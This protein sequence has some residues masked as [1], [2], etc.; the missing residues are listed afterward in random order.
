[1][2][3][4]FI[5]NHQEKIDKSGVEIFARSVGAQLLSAMN[6]PDS[7]WANGD[8]SSV[9]PPHNPDTGNYYSGVNFLQLTLAGN[10]G[11]PRWLTSKGMEKN[12]LY[13]S[14][15][16]S[17]ESI[18]HVGTTNFLPVINKETGEHERDLDGALKYEAF[19]RDNPVFTAFKLTN[20]SN[21]DGIESYKTPIRDQGFINARLYE[22]L[23][24][25]GATFKHGDF[26]PRYDEVEDVIYL[27]SRES[28]ESA[29]EY[30]SVAVEQ[31]GR[32][33][34]HKERL[35][36]E[37][38]FDEKTSSEYY[39][40][41]LVSQISNF[42]TAVKVGSKFSPEQFKD[43]TN[44]W[45]RLLDEDP[46]ALL[47]ACSDAQEINNYILSG[48][49]IKRET[50]EYM[51]S[52]EGLEKDIDGR[53]LT[54]SE[55]AFDKHFPKSKDPTVM[56]IEKFEESKAIDG[57]FAGE[58][59]IVDAVKAGGV[60]LTVDVLRVVAKENGLN[61]IT[62]YNDLK[63]DF[64]IGVEHD[65][66]GNIGLKFGV[67]RDN[68]IIAYSYDPQKESY[69]EL[70]SSDPLVIAQEIKNATDVYKQDQIKTH[71]AIKGLESY[72]LD[73]KQDQRSLWAE[74]VKNDIDNNPVKTMLKATEVVRGNDME[75][76]IVNLEN[77]IN[78]RI[79]NEMGYTGLD[80][81]VSKSS[82]KC[83]IFLDNE[84][85]GKP[86]NSKFS[87]INKNLSE[88]INSLK[89]RE[90][91][92]VNEAE[93]KQNNSLVSGGYGASLEKFG[94]MK[95]TLSGIEMSYRGN[96]VSFRDINQGEAFGLSITS[97]G[98]DVGAVAYADDERDGEMVVVMV[99]PYATN[100]SQLD[101]LRGRIADAPKLIK[102]T[103]KNRDQLRARIIKDVERVS[104]LFA[105]PEKAKNLMVSSFED[106][107]MSDNLAFAVL[108]A[109][110][111]IKGKGLSPRFSV[112]E[113][114]LT[115]GKTQAFITVGIE[116]IPRNQM[117]IRLHPVG[118][119]ELILNGRRSN[120]DVRPLR[121]TGIANESR[122]VMVGV[123]AVR[124]MEM[125]AKERPATEKTWIYIN[126]QDKSG[127]EEAKSYG[128]RWDK[129]V[130]CW[131]VD[132]GNDLNKFEKWLDPTFDP[133]AS[134][135]EQFAQALR[136]EGFII[137]ASDIVI[138]NN[139][140]KLTSCKVVGDKGSQKSGRYTM[141]SADFN[142][143]G[144]A[145]GVYTNH[146]LGGGEKMK[147]WSEVGTGIKLTSEQKAQ[148]AK[149]T[150]IRMKEAEEQ[151]AIKYERGG[152]IARALWDEAKGVVGTMSH[153]YV[154]NKNIL[155]HKPLR[156]APLV[157]SSEAHALGIRIAENPKERALILEDARA[158]KED[159][160]VFIAGEL[161]IPA[162]N[163]NGEIRS[164]QKIGS[165][166]TFMSGG[167]KTNNFYTTDGK[168]PSGKAE[169]IIAEGYATADSV[170]RLSRG[171]QVVVAFDVGNMVNVAKL[172]RETYP[173]ARITIA[174]D[175][176][177]H[178]GA[179]KNIGLNKANEVA[180]EIGAIV[181]TPPFNRGAL[182]TDWNDL[183]VEY[184]VSRASEIYQS[185]R[186]EAIA[187]AESRLDV[188]KGSEVADIEIDSDD[189]DR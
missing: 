21:I 146:R 29:E 159:V 91:E 3:N 114:V 63:S 14:E 46:L 37:S 138:T 180:K 184:G 130:K 108:G 121:I 112:D 30:L 58:R 140:N 77:V 32:W 39:K 85:V 84:R 118:K 34:C 50:N 132:R 172:M 44:T 139:R 167:E 158:N 117:H 143:S 43:Y 93:I 150:A 153:R 87:S 141:Y 135:V 189:M 92:A 166:K 25:S 173:D 96:D 57:F 71:G 162:M 70:M 68:G 178:K 126:V 15:G 10:G 59:E 4:K 53:V 164:L 149:M 102:D 113:V 47:V 26:E 177:H 124:Q 151:K 161:L 41:Q 45:E 55:I 86:F 2:E 64:E 24:D 116:N 185:V 17:T 48:Q 49:E 168:V 1:M 75:A 163:I 144:R 40:D 104:K 131:Y 5:A 179:E 31:L 54:S 72:F 128:A 169:I 76:N 22:I 67:D 74:Y 115:G 78:I 157:I 36:K 23:S 13:P 165:Q 99:D 62:K 61:L 6:D 12:G 82:G 156:V 133:E 9:F 125:K 147:G 7:V 122:A 8:T 186:A 51:V 38:I 148:I 188:E 20:G 33:A 18:V 142:T 69:V 103:Q 28:Y 11:D 56:T 52:D 79:H 187:E 73:A 160:T 83:L 136:S 109:E 89:S 100:G 19:E 175:N 65:L 97:S 106:R 110:N 81:K 16:A 27:P 66:G 94:E 145:G 101:S 181:V 127:R 80:L 42:M 105:N 155:N 90:I 176:D 95:Q 129:E 111:E 171:K 170:S 35:N 134:P 183:M 182:G 174:S 152:E 88:A 60:N 154:Q 120:A 107:P 119:D 123:D 137:E 98:K